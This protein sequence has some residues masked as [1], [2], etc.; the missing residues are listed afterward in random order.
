MQSTSILYRTLVLGGASCAVV[1]APLLLVSQSWSTAL[2][3]ALLALLLAL[4]AISRTR[5]ENVEALQTLQASLVRLDKYTGQTHAAVDP[6]EPQAL[7]RLVERVY[8][9]A[10]DV[11]QRAATRGVEEQRMRESSA[12]LETVLG[13]MGEGVV[14]VS[15]DGRVL[16]A[17]A[18]A[19]SLLEIRSTD[20]QG[21]PLMEVARATELEDLHREVLTGS[22]QIRREI[23]IKRRRAILEVVATKLPTSPVPGAV[24]VMHNVTSLRELE[25]TRRDFVSNVSHEL[26]SPLTA[27]QA[28]ADTLLDGGLEDKTNNTVFVARIIEQ[29][30]R[31]QELIED[32]L[33]LAR[34]ESQMEAFDVR[35][36]NVGRVIRES[37]AS[38]EAVAAARGVELRLSAP[39]LDAEVIA[40]DS[41]MRAIIDNLIS[42]AI[43]Y[44]N[45]GGS[46]NV[47]WRTQS[48]EV[49]LEVQDDGIGI[50]AEHHDRIFERFYRVERARSRAGGGTGLGLAIVKHLT[51]LFGGTIELESAV[52]QGSLFRVRLPLAAPSRV[53]A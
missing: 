49:V 44:S 37:V 34:I 20:I 12:L 3:G 18:V 45:P 25:R 10:A 40:D 53:S 30:N 46:V 31:L 28:Y 41:G 14:V 16:F 11:E 21:R 19:R 17:N 47:R 4:F 1:G 2:C 38:R 13:S 6:R 50:A 33:R 29:A 52:G 23:H 32:M 8:Q 22:T 42:N 43:N 7:D 5:L 27:I 51:G 26:K 24:L 35:P 9:G 48:A 15:G 36:V 39:P